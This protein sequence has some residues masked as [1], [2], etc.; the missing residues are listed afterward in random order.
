MAQGKS[1]EKSIL[2]K[3]TDTMKGLADTASQALKSEEP[4]RVDESAAAYM[5]FAAE[6]M[7]SD[8]PPVPPIATPPARRK[9]APSEKGKRRAAKRSRKTAAS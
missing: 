5:P 8:L 2:D 4:A 9:R 1:K 6:G 3:F 7:V